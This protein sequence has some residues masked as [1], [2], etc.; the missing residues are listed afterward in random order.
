MYLD[1][2][3]WFYLDLG[4]FKWIS[5]VSGV[6]SRAACG[7]LCRPVVPES[8]SPLQTSPLS[9]TYSFWSLEAWMPGCLEA[10]RL[11]LYL[12]AFESWTAGIGGLPGVLTRSTL[13]EVGGKKEGER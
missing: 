12:S 5:G 10:W 2:F 3:R 9:N 7:A 11:G 6:E 8:S 4:G 13:R 1:G